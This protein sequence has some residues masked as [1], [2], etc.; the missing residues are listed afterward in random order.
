MRRAVAIGVCVLAV[1]ACQLPQDGPRGAG[2]LTFY[3]SPPRGANPEACWGKDES[4]AVIETVTERLL[5]TPEVLAEDGT[6]KSEAVYAERSV[7]RIVQ[8]RREQWFETPC[9]DKYTPDIVASL[10]RALSVRGLYGGAIDGEMNAG[11]RAAVRAYQA[12]R[13]LDSQVL[14]LEAALQLGLV[15]FG[16][17]RA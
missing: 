8:E 9:Q 15:A 16:R 10:Q 13:G 6:V 11:T 5:V 17:A 2:A 4:P 7:Q 1:A 12:P 3:D 14:S